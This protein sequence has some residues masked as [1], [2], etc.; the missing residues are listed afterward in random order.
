MSEKSEVMRPA[1]DSR[2]RLIQLAQ[3]HIENWRAFY[4]RVRLIQTCQIEILKPIIEAESPWQ[5]FEHANAAGEIDR[6]RGHYD[7]FREFLESDA[8]FQIKRPPEEL[9]PHLAKMLSDP[10]LVAKL[11]AGQAKLFSHDSQAKHWHDEMVSKVDDR[12]SLENPTRLKFQEW[13]RECEAQIEYY[14]NAH[15]AHVSFLNALIAELML[16]IDDGPIPPKSFSWRS[17]SVEMEPKPY[18]LLSFLWNAPGRKAKVADV[19]ME[20]W[21]EESETDSRLKTASNKANAA[22]LE[23]KSPLQIKKSGTW[24]ILS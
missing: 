2:K 20:V 14:R 19:E 4:H 6:L 7:A 3:S 9:N 10:E 1:L 17:N 24:L 23:L 8:A 5:A 15:D 18:T 21:G 16:Q 22:L 12:N 11:Q 13:R